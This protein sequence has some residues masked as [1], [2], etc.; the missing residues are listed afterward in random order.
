MSRVLPLSLGV[1]ALAVVHRAMR[2]IEHVP[3]GVM[4]TDAREWA[5]AWALK[6]LDRRMH[7]VDAG[8]DFVEVVDLEPEVVQAALTP[9][10]PEIEVEAKV[11]IT[12]CASGVPFKEGSHAK[13]TLV[14]QLTALRI[15]SDDRDVL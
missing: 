14:E 13:E 7:A 1:D 11:A 12:D 4:R 2:Q 6:Q 3:L 15:R 5:R 8:A 10:G 9:G